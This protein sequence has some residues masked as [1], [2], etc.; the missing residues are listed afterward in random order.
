M[1]MTLPSGLKFRCERKI[2]LQRDARR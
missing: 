2:L 1:K